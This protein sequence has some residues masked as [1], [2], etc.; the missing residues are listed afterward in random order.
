MSAFVV[1]EVEVTDAAAYEPYRTLAEQS[2][3]RFGGRFLARGGSAALLEGE[4][5]PKRIVIIE[6]ADAEAARRWYGSAE[7]QAAAKIR[8]QASRGRLI[9]V[10]GVD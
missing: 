4:G 1:A 7:Y 6:F 9:L 5:A 2:I 8:Q 10:D 3:A